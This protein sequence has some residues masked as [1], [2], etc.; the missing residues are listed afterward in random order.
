MVLVSP[1]KIAAV[2]A[3][4]PAP[5]SLAELDEMVSR[6]LPAGALKASSGHI[7]MSADAPEGGSVE[8]HDAI[9]LPEAWDAAS[10]AAARCFG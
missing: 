2:M 7:C 5:H 6:G 9:S 10:T 8:R 1:E 3:L 4:A